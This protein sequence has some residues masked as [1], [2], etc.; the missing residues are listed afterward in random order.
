[1]KP[2]TTEEIFESDPRIQRIL[3]FGKGV[4]RTF[5]REY[6]V[7]RREDPFFQGPA[8]PVPNILLR[9]AWRGPRIPP[10]DQILASGY[11]VTEGGRLG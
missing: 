6:R 8:A 1:M 10:T 4:Y 7:Y 11:V 9:A 3:V 5:I 2:R